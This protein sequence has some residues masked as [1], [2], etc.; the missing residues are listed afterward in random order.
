[1]KYANVIADACNAV[2]FLRFFYEASR[3]VEHFTHRDVLEVGD[4]VVIDNF[5]AHNG[6]A[7]RALRVYLEKFGN[8]TSF[9]SS[10]F[11]RYESC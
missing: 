6:E 7:E 5:S 10:I 2:E 8:R 1:M 11:T 9:P 3:T 4:I